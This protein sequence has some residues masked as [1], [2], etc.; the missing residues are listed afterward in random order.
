MVS[1]TVFAAD[2]TAARAVA[3]AANFRG[4]RRVSEGCRGNGR[5]R[6]PMSVDIASVGR[7]PKLPWQLP[8]I[9]VDFRGYCRVAVAMTADGRGNFR[10]NCRGLSRVAMVGTTEFA[11]DGQ[12]HHTPWPQPWQLPWKCHKPW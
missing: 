11:T 5:G 4:N 6:S 12:P 9:S 3:I 1:T 8:R 10:D 2:R 7:P